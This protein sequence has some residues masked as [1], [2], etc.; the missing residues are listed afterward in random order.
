MTAHG[1]TSGMPS[2]GDGLRPRHCVMLDGWHVNN[3]RPRRSDPMIRLL[4]VDDHDLVRDMV[5]AALRRH[6]GMEVVGACADGQ[7]AVHAFRTLRPDVVVMDLSMPVMSGADATRE[8]LAVDPSARVVVLTSSHVGRDIG[9]ALA[10][11]A[12]AWVHKDAGQDALVRAVTA[13]ATGPD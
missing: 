13:A 10:A 7:Q 12:L 5:V 8:L 9:H 4:V 3:P 11:G 1:A 6:A 2:I